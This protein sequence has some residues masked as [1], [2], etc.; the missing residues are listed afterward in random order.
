MWL[1][2]SPWRLRD[3]IAYD[4]ATPQRLRI[5]SAARFAFGLLVAILGF[6]VF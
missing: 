1:T 4:T 3:W 2:I 6:V 5:F